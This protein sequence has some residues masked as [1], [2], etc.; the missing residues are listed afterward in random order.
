MKTTLTAVI[1]A[2]STFAIAAPASA[3]RHRCGNVAPADWMSVGDITAKAVAL[4]YQV[5]EVERDDG[6]YEIKA[7]D[8]SGQR[9]DV[10]M[11]PATGAVV[12]TDFDD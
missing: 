10:H 8:N 3:D 5:R 1:L 11:H 7:T 12:W 4:G 9:I 2:I 6:C